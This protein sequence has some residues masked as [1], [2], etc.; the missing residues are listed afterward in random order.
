MRQQFSAESEDEERGV[1]CLK[2]GEKKYEILI[3]IWRVQKGVNYDVPSVS[4]PTFSAPFKIVYACTL[5]Q[6]RKKQ[7]AHNLNKL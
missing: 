3:T 5:E 6:Q 2:I 4:Q 7:L 1:E